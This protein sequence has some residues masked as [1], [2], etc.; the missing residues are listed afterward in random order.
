MASSCSRACVG[1]AESI[2][3]SQVLGFDE[4]LAPA[5][6]SSYLG[7]DDGISDGESMRRMSAPRPVSPSRPRAGS[8]P[9]QDPR[10][11]PPTPGVAPTAP[12]L[13]AASPERSRTLPPAGAL[14]IGVA[15]MGGHSPSGMIRIFTLAPYLTDCELDDLARLF[16]AW[17]HI[18]TA[19]SARRQPSDV[20]TLGPSAHE[21]VPVAGGHGQLRVGAR[22]RDDGWHDTWWT[23][24]MHRLRHLF[25]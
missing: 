13:A 19:A 2:A 23:R 6:A 4:S 24:F 1:A 20:E 25:G 22:P 16:P 18:A 11:D 5:N 14:A 7:S 3:D 10:L 12:L 8:D 9:F 17:L 15:S 21:V